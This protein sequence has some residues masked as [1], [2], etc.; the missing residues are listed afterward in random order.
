[1]GDALPGGPRRGEGPAWSCSASSPGSRLRCS[2]APMLA[3]SSSCPDEAAAAASWSVIVCAQAVEPGHRRPARQ[4]LFPAA[5]PV[6]APFPIPEHN[7]PRPNPTFVGA[8]GGAEDAGGSARRH[9]PRRHH[10]AAGDQ[11]TGRRRQDPAR[12]RLR[13]RAPRRVRPDPLAA[14][15]GAGGA[16]RRLRRHGAGARARPDARPGSADRRDPRQ[17]G[18]PAA[19]AARVRQ[20]HRARIA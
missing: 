15:R 3:I 9:R 20:R 8:S 5:G 14:R 13:L 2:A 18:A 10:P 19:L 12:A 17:A 16:R 1:M 7:L 11:R 6:E 4:R